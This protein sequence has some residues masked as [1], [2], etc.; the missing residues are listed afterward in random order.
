MG[1]N[2]RILKGLK[3]AM[4]AE[5]DGHNFYKMAAN[6]TNDEEGK[7]VFLQLAQDEVEHF[8]FLKAQYDS[9]IETG[10]VDMNVKLGK[11]STEANESPIFSEGFKSRLNEAHLEMS[12]LSI[13]AQLELSAV[14]FYQ[15]EAEVI[16]DP[17]VKQFYTEL[18]E[19]EKGH[20]RR[21]IKQQQEL[22]DDYWDAAG[23]Q[24]F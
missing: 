20:H 18:A 17:A 16:D 6:N 5:A 13:G 21:L 24:P 19:W 4:Q 15:K 3:Q 11:P 8:I 9:I 14:Q 10:K 7:E 1:N 2:E 23:F 12:A 22:Q